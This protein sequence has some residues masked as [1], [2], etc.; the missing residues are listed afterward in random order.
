MRSNARGR[1]AIILAVLAISIITGLATLGAAPRQE[2]VP[3]QPFGAVFYS[4]EISVEGKQA[5]AGLDLIACIDDCASVFES[6]PTRV[7]DGGRYSMLAVSPTDPELVGR[8]VGFY[9]VNEFGRIK[10]VEADRFEGDFNVYTMSLTFTDPIPTFI[11]VPEV[12]ASIAALSL[13]PTTGLVSTASGTGF[14]PG[15][16]LR[17]TWGDALLGVAAVDPSGGFTAVVGA[18]SVGAGDYVITATGEAG[19]TAVATL[20]VPDL[21]GPVGGPGPKG[22]TGPA[23]RSGGA[24]PAG[25][26]GNQ[27]LRGVEGPM[28]EAGPP[29]RAGP[30]G[31]AGP[32]GLTGTIGAAGAKGD[33]GSLVFGIIALALA[34]GTV[35]GTAGTFFYLKGRYESLVR[36]L[37]PPGLR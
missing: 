37:P 14:V 27:G 33:A 18:P 13:T 30:A 2:G 9:I 1:H 21:T 19:E 7:E 8:I 23:G 17:L 16:T 35:A 6:L 24:G 31:S 36:R 11:A 3:P 32:Q 15:S 20:T 12:I 5:P 26:K 10:A 4:G 22:E 29:G 34:A 28:P 25:P